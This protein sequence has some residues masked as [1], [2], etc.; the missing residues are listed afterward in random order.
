MT[1]HWPHGASSAPSGPRAELIGGPP[2]DEKTRRAV[3]LRR[4]RTQA[5]RAARETAYYGRVFAELGL[6]P[7]RLS[8]QDVGRLPTTPKSALRDDPDAFVRRT[9]TPYLRSLTTGTTG[10]PTSVYFST[11]ELH[12]MVALSALGFLSSGQL[13]PE[14]VVQI[15]TSSRAV[16]GNLGLAGACARIGALGYVAGLLEPEQTLAMLAE[17]R[18]IPGKKRRTSVMSTY[19]SYLGQLVECDLRLGYR[20]TDFGIERVFCGG[21]IVTAGLKERS[22]A[23]FGPVDFFENYAMTELLPLGGHLCEQGHLHFEVSHGLIEVRSLDGDDPALP[24][25]AGTIIATPFPPYRETTLL[26]R[27]DTEDVVRAL[28]RPLDCSLRN[29]PATGHLLGKRRLSVQHEDGWTFPRD[30]IEA[31]EALNAVPLPARCGF[32]TVPGG[33]AVQVV[34]GEDT[35]EARRRVGAALE[36]RG[37]PLRELRL[38]EDPRSLERPLPLRGDLRETSFGLPPD[39]AGG[40]LRSPSKRDLSG[41]LS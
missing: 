12:L 2:L 4:F 23:L 6:D 22:R 40:S 29:L 20:P 26:L 24:G 27:Y 5:S 30:V 28:A 31:L 36:A 39:G 15:S 33:V 13:G 37:V 38:V 19:P 17:E 7:A 25:Q 10:P 18:R 3:Q 11:Y 1:L 14:D 16:L 8:E 9:A 32:W 41:R 35:N 21:E 34:V